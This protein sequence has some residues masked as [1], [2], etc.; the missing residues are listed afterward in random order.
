MAP[1][2]YRRLD[3]TRPYKPLDFGNGRLAGSVAPDGRLLALGIY[4][5]KHGYL[6]LSSAAPFPDEH[7]SDQAAVRAYRAALAQPAAPT[8][9]LR[10]PAPS[11]AAEVFLLEDG[12]PQSRFAVGP[13]RVSVTTWAPR[14]SGDVVSAALQVWQFQNPTGQSA[15][16]DYTWDGTLTLSRANY[17]QLTESG[18]LPPLTPNLHLTFDGRV[19]RAVAPEIG[20]AAVVLGLP[21]GPAWQQSG[22]SPLPAAVTGHL[23]VPPKQIV[24]LTLVY[25]LAPTLEEAQ[26]VADSLAVAKPESMLRDALD[27][28]LT[29]WSALE[30]CTADP[31]RFLARRARAYVLD[32]CALPVG[33]GICLLTDH[34]ILPLSW[35]RDAYFLLQ[36]LGAGTTEAPLDL[37]RRHLLW[38]FETARRPGG[39]W[40]RAY[41]ANGHPKDRIFQLDQQ[42]YPLLELVE[43]ATATD[44]EATVIRLLPHLPAILDAVL[45][46]RAGETALFA[47]EETPADDP[48]PLPYHFSSQV[49]LWHTLHQLTDLNARWPFT[50][51]DLEGLAEAVRKAVR[52]HLVV[53]HRGRHLFA[54]ATDLR[55]GYRFYHDANDF[56]TVLA[57]LWGFC[58]L[59]EPVWRATMDFAFS[60]DN[61]GG[62]YPGPYGGLGSVH[63]PGPWPLGDIQEFL[64]ARLIGDE[65]RAQ[66]VLARLIATACWDGA[67]PEARDERGGEVRSRHWFAWPSAALAAALTHPAWQPQR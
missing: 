35:T 54:Y 42:C 27:E 19:L 17:T 43:Y 11:T 14:V 22:Q 39:Y 37:V 56:P 66:T 46:R 5:P 29:R 62:Y 61:A 25:V 23:T 12:V 60:P 1:P 10:P 6:T 31:A 50:S 64:Y 53:E 48:L 65:T 59:D 55:G 4:H 20:G 52:Q 41:L 32:C 3:P 18:A 33:E 36:G 21:P 38:L 44:D 34:Q 67:L 45:A 47:T 9:G 49:L 8:F 58:A 24:D 28:Y 26:T 51:L 13:V 16:L 30:Q 57:P 40:G 63:T 15:A 7:R 2:F